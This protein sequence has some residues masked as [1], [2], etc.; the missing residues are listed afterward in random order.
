M[1]FTRSILFPFCFFSCWELVW[2]TFIIM[3]IRPLFA[4]IFY[5]SHILLY[6]MSNM[7]TFILLVSLNSC[8][9]FSLCSVRVTSIPTFLKIFGYRSFGCKFRFFVD[10][11]PTAGNQA[12]TLN[13]WIY[14]IPTD[15]QAGTLNILYPKA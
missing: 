4:L 3:L 6:F 2:L 1:L 8:R 9:E 11:H 5:Q 7:S 13:I 10:P 15:C 14:Y 12:R